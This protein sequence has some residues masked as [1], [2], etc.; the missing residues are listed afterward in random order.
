MEVGSAKVAVVA[1]G[2]VRLKAAAVV[3]S[4]GNF[5]FMYGVNVGADLFATVSALSAFPWAPRSF[6]IAALP[7]KA[8][9][10]GGTSQTE[11]KRS[12]YEI[13]LGP[14]TKPGAISNRSK[15]GLVKRAPVVG[16]LLSLSKSYLFCHILNPVQQTPHL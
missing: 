10:K 9:K 7:A 16:P 13:L 12:I 14:K 8:A 6:P 3:S 15:Y 5:L 4:S 1:D 2:W 11:Q